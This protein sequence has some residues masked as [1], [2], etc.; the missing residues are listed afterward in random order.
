MLPPQ[1]SP[2]SSASVSVRSKL[3]RF[4]LSRRMTAAASRQTSASTQPPPM[5]PSWEPS[6]K[7]SI[8][9]A[10]RRGVEPLRATMVAS[11]P[12]RP[13]RRRSTISWY[14][15]PSMK[16]H[17]ALARQK[18]AREAAFAPLQDGEL[19]CS[20]CGLGSERT[21]LLVRLAREAGPRAGLCGA[22]ITGGGSGGTVAIL[23]SSD[24]GGAVARVAELYRGI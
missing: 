15:S 20:A 2:L 14:G 6:S 5:L 16:E 7:T 12:R 18:R 11:A 17:Y 23:A 8:L 22:E 24:A 1:R 9:A 4:G 3:S 10:S 13:L 19:M 21:D